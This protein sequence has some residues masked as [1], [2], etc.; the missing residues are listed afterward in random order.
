[1]IKK[2]VLVFIIVITC[3]SSLKAQNASEKYVDYEWMFWTSINSTFRLSDRWGAMADF[4]VRRKNFIKDPNFYFF[5]LG[6]VYWLDDKFSAA[7]GAAGLW[8][9]TETEAGLKYALEKR[10]YQQIL[11]RNE[12]KR[13]T[14]LQRIRVEQRWHEVLNRSTGEV[15]RTRY[16]NRF[17]SLMSAS[18]Q[19][20]EDKYLPK[21]VIADEIHFHTGKG[22]VYNTF[23]QN[24]LFLG[25]NQRISKNL[26]FDMGYMMVYQQTYL[27]NA[28][29]FMNTFRLFFYYSPDW[30]KKGKLP[31]YS[32]P[33]EQ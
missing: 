28:Y 5:R 15:D 32:I 19:L 6:G 2:V 22:I 25:I 1:M 13:I 26:T 30:R 31:H 4:H 27:G 8:L 10:T 21:L 9:A 17:R 18:V 7:G 3:C 24:R 14:F 23:D 29:S 33:G 12:I 16:S 11:W 20:F